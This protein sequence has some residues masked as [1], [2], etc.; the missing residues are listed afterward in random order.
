MKKKKKSNNKTIT[1][2]KFPKFDWTDDFV[3]NN[4]KLVLIRKQF[5]CEL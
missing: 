2:L 3:T 4:Q 1:T 5:S